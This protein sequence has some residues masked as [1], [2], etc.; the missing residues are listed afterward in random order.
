[1]ISIELKDKTVIVTGA[2]GGIGAGCAERFAQA[3]ANV[4]LIGR[5]YEKIRLQAEKI[6]NLTG[7]QCYAFAADVSKE[8]EFEQI[9]LFT[10]H[11]L[12]PVDILVN[13]AG[14]ALRKPVSEL[15]QSEIDN[16]LDINT[17][18]VIYSCRA[19]SKRMI[20]KNCGSIINISSI[21]ARLGQEHLHLYAA[22]KA[23][24]IALTQSLANE[25]AKYDIRVNTVLP[26]HV[27][28]PM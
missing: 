2:G 18:S 12:S 14:I 22:S 1:M 25:F 17:K 20:P 4:V 21:A 10:E 23:A 24:V 13:C 16:V 9:M 11:H 19:A 15:T 28:T 5:T 27:L 7:Q 3:G 6:S 8:E 26:G